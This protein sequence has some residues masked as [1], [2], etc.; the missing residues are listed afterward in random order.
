MFISDAEGF[1]RIDLKELTAHELKVLFSDIRMEVLSRMAK[2]APTTKPFSQK[3]TTLTGQATCV[4]T[5]LG[6][7]KDIVTRLRLDTGAEVSFHDVITPS[8]ICVLKAME[9][10]Q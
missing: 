7:S 4:G 9:E 6:P 10:A 3:I 5:G 8:L 2:L 1:K